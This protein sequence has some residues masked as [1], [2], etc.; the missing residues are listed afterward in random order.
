MADN[1]CRALTLLET[2]A[3]KG[4]FSSHLD[5]KAEA[6]DLIKKGIRNDITSHIC[7]CILILA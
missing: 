1:P 4:L 2:L 7:E 3:M 6:H 5:K